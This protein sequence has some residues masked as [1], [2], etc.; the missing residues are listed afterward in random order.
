MP[1]KSE[2]LPASFTIGSLL[3][4]IAALLYWNS[5][6]ISAPWGFTLALFCV[7][8][9]VASL[10][11]SELRPLPNYHASEWQLDRLHVDNM[12]RAAEFLLE[13]DANYPIMLQ[14]SGEVKALLLD[15]VSGFKLGYNWQGL[16]IRLLY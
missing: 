16:L 11:V 4:F 13:E 10:L 9:F 14:P 15:Y 8:V 1:F 12:R 2:P 7:I 3:G 6:K 5:G